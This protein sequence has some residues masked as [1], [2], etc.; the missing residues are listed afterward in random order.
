LIRIRQDLI[1]YIKG[2]TKF[3]QP[4]RTAL[5]VK[6]TALQRD[7]YKWSMAQGELMPCL[8]YARSQE[9]YSFSFISSLADD[10]SPELRAATKSS[11]VPTTDIMDVDTIEN[12]QLWLPSDMPA[13]V[14]LQ[15]ST[16]IMSLFSALQRIGLWY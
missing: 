4:Q 7:I 10:P 1:A 12:V 13:A 15:V 2:V 5:Q 9:D 14:R 3:S 8:K 11:D 16:I 6:R